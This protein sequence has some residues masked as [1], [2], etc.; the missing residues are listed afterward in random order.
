[1]TSAT[2]S[3]DGRSELWP[4]S[5]RAVFG[6]VLAA[7][8]AGLLV[9]YYGASGTTEVGDQVVWVN[10][11]AAGL[12]LSGAG[13]VAFLAAG[14]R[15]VGRRRLALFGDVPG[16]G[17]VDVTDEHGARSDAGTLV[18]APAMT[19]YHRHGCA[20]TEGRSVAAA[21]RSEHERAGRRPCGVCLTPEAVEAAQ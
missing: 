7:G 19:R 8:L 14:R 10:V 18:A 6:V 12:L 16:A 21:S 13:I 17:A 3:S 1:M 9:A 11:G 15:A 20:F 4:G 2:S 5:N